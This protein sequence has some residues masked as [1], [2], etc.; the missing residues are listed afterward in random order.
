MR[1]YDLAIHG[2]GLL[3][4]LLA[5]HLLGCDP[6]QALLLAFTD[7]EPCGDKLEPVLEASL[8]APARALVDPFIVREW[9]RF[10]VTRQGETTEHPGT[11]L[12]L[13]PVQVWLELRGL[14]PDAAMPAACTDLQWAAPVLSWDDHRVEAGAYVDLSVFASDGCSEIVG[15]TGGTGLP[16]PVMADFDVGDEPWD[17]FQHLPLGDDR[18]YIRKRRC[19]GPVE[20]AL[21]AG[22]GRALSDLMGR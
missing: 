18:I 4:G 19:R 10:L 3:P 17:A 11:V 6:G 20:D 7:A 5:I 13:D 8:S 15:G 9:P 12:L 21:I 22:F 16:L 14:L 2:S 1:R